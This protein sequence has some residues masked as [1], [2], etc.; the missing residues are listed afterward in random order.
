[1]PSIFP[2]TSI[3]TIKLSKD[4]NFLFKKKSMKIILNSS[5]ENVYPNDLI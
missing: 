1:M 3:K 5:N 2:K 4:N